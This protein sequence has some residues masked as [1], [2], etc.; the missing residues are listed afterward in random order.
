VLLGLNRRSK[1][2]QFKPPTAWGAASSGFSVFTLDFLESFVINQI[3]FIFS[4]MASF[5]KGIILKRQNDL[6]LVGLTIEAFH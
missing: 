2:D 1:G 4:S 3:I 6:L 5:S